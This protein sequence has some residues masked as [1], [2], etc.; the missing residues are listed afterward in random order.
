MSAKAFGTPL[1]SYEDFFSAKN[2]S[3]NRIISRSK[4]NFGADPRAVVNSF[5]QRGFFPQTRR[6]L[7]NGSP[8]VNFSTSPIQNNSRPI[9]TSSPGF[10]T[11]QN[12]GSVPIYNPGPT[13]SIPKQ[14]LNI[15]VNA[16]SDEVFSID[17]DLLA[18]CEGYGRYDS[19]TGMCDNSGV[20]G[21]HAGCGGFPPC[22]QSGLMAK[23]SFNVVMRTIV[24]PGY[25]LQINGVPSD[26]SGLEFYDHEG[27][28]ITGQ[29]GELLH[30]MASS[31][32]ITTFVRDWFES[33]DISEGMFL[34]NGALRALSI[35]ASCPPTPD[36]FP[37]YEDWVNG[38]CSGGMSQVLNSRFVSGASSINTK[39]SVAI[40][41]TVERE[42]DPCAFRDCNRETGIETCRGGYHGA[43]SFSMEILS[44]TYHL[45]WIQGVVRQYES[46][47]WTISPGSQNALD[48]LCPI[49]AVTD[50][51]IDPLCGTTPL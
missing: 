21:P 34:S 12:L 28:L 44:D 36:E 43:P 41:V 6:I 1:F 45:G 17:L 39:R 51:D 11:P 13:D 22:C 29:D 3:R 48:F 27:N 33:T 5:Q 16:G 46:M 24:S 10:F 14:C 50:R 2:N 23:K 30:I 37:V 35:S 9:P 18:P 42:W 31:S 26:P 38:R 4:F 7:R 25:S 20:V 40:R 32:Q 47:T 15:P 19:S 8:Q 49:G